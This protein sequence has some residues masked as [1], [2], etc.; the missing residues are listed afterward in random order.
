MMAEIREWLQRLP[1][2][3]P[4]DTER[5]WA[6]FQESRRPG[7]RRWELL[8]LPAVAAAALL[9]WLTPEAPRREPLEAA[10]TAAW[11]DEVS[12]AFDGR[13]VASGVDR[14][15]LL[16]WEAGTVR[17]DV[18]PHAGNR[19]RVST[20]EATVTVTGTIFSVRRDTLGV[21][22][23]VERGSVEVRCADGWV[24]AVTPAD[25]PRTC[26]PVRAAAL[27]G[28]A[29][30]LLE[31]GAAPAEVRDTVDRGLAVAEAGSPVEGELLAHRVRVGTDEGRVEEVAADAD[32]YLGS[33]HAGRRVEVLRAAGRLVY[34]ERGCA[35]ALRFLEPLATEGDAE[36][37]VVLA[38]C[39]PDRGR[40]LS[41]A[42][43]ALRSGQGIEPGWRA[44]AE[45]LLARE[46]R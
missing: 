40:A 9:L 20:E 1:D 10:G 8:L 35:A 30:A 43:E 38:A 36:D 27:L 29:N 23:Q 15:L 12:L 46:G 17:V 21:T 4:R 33:G 14:D 31:A 41:L 44:W 2:P 34:R 22:T 18:T 16:E 13:G 11:S 42:R 7:R 32:R 45:D 37:R 6:R 19:V 39:T 28:R 25:G 24:G 3:D 5:V 26:L